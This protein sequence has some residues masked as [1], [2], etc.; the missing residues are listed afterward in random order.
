MLG[1]WRTMLVEGEAYDKCT[2][3]STIVSL[4]YL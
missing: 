3:C 4:H 2:G 1:Q